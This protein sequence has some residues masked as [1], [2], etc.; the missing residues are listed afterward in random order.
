MLGKKTEAEVIIRLDQQEQKAHVCVVAWPAMLRKMTK[1]HGESLDGA[2]PQH[3]A[4]WVVPISA[5]RIRSG[6]RK[7]GRAPSAGFLAARARQNGQFDG[8]T[9]ENGVPGH[10]SPQ[11]PANTAENKPQKTEVCK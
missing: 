7:V 1:L 3:S 6:K 10:E 2:D 5:I 8:L 11:I 4:R 9:P